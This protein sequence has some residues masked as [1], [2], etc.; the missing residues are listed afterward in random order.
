M[1]GRRNKSFFVGCYTWIAVFVACIPVI[2]FDFKNTDEW[3]N[4]EKFKNSKC[5]ES[6]KS[7]NNIVYP[8]PSTTG[9]Y[10]AIVSDS[11]ETL[12]TGPGRCGNCTTTVIFNYNNKKQVYTVIK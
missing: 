2:A 4:F 8:Y 7:F 5:Y 10:Y 6:K 3:K 9:F 1:Y 11:G 12:Y